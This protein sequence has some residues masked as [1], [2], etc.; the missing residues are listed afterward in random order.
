MA[1]TAS[2]VRVRGYRETARAFNRMSGALGP[3]LTAGLKEAAEPVAR[4]AQSL[5]SQYA[6]AKTS[7][8]GPRVSVRGVYVTQ[9]ARK[10]TG[11]RA[12][13][14]ALQMTRAFIPALEHHVDE[15][16]AGAAR[17]LELVERLGGF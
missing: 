16:E 1:A 11:L 13:F 3:T 5:V 12:D 14:G 15:V 9:R 17:A 8:I 2:T 4:E 7:T 6:G 10:K